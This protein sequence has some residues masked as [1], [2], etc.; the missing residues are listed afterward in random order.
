MGSYDRCHF[1]LDMRK[2]KIHYWKKYAKKNTLCGIGAEFA[3]IVGN[4][5]GDVNCK[6]C[7]R[8]HK[9]RLKRERN[10]T[11]EERRLATLA[12]IKNNEKF[13]K[14]LRA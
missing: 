2:L 14:R 4:T 7:K 10:R 3:Q 12:K 11:P 8:L 9:F 6:N 1:R 5:E 13:M